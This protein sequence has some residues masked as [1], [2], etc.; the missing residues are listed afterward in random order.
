L[1]SILFCC[2]VNDLDRVWFYFFKMYY[3]GIICRKMHNRKD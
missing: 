1:Y 2:I 3:L